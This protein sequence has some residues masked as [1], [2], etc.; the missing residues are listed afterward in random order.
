M[1]CL[2]DLRRNLD[3]WSDDVFKTESF[4]NSD[5]T[6]N[7]LNQFGCFAKHSEWANQWESAPINP[8]PVATAYGSRPMESRLSGC[9]PEK[10]NVRIEMSGISKWTLKS[11]KTFLFQSLIR[12][13][14]DDIWDF[15]KKMRSDHF[16]TTSSCACVSFSMKILVRAACWPWHAALA[17]DFQPLTELLAKDDRCHGIPFLD[18][19]VPVSCGKKYEPV[20][21]VTTCRQEHWHQWSQ[22]WLGRSFPHTSVWATASCF[23]RFEPVGDCWIMDKIMSNWRFSL[24]AHYINIFDN[25]KTTRFSHVFTAWESS[26]SRILGLSQSF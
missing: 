7:L 23:K 22:H 21:T 25:Y 9:V 1:E 4:D 24:S 8:F 12:A 20:T 13:F 2:D 26:S 18:L 17:S 11:L 10:A 6:S 5:L 15:Q 14:I 3:A 19:A 16:K